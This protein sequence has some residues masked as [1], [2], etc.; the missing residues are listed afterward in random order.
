[1]IEIMSK[2]L[3]LVAMIIR[4]SRMASTGFVTVPK[5]NTDG[6]PNVSVPIFNDLPNGRCPAAAWYRSSAMAC[7]PAGAADS[8]SERASVDEVL[9]RTVDVQLDLP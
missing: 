2:A 8:N 3:V 4:V 9:Y 6:R 7:M 1:M 5:R